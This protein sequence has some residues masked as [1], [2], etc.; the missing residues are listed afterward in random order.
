MLMRI[1][2]VVWIA[3][4]LPLSF[5][6][7]GA[8]TQQLGPDPGKALADEFG[9]WALR[10]LLVALTLRPLRDISGKPQFVQIRR[11]V[12]L[13]AWFY[14]SLHFAAGLFYV[15]GWSF[16]DL[17]KAFSERRYITLGLLA[18][19]L[20]LPLGLTSNRWSQR[21]LGLR[22]RALHRL[23]YPMA[24]FACLHF[25]W[26]VREDYRQPVLYAL[27]LCL[28]L[29]WRVPVLRKML[30]HSSNGRSQRVV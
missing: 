4:L 13:F 25:I 7:Y 8:L 15:I 9:L 17:L 18:W 5:I 11:L 2:V 28:L 20:M 22:W 14:A 29:L 26:L 10:L 24:I 30:L 3:C 19:L 12:S 16:A 27:L 6:M 1:K 23:V 21:K